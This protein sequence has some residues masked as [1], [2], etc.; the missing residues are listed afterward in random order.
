[1]RITCVT[2]GLL[3]FTPPGLEC[4]HVLPVQGQTRMAGILE[5]TDSSSFPPYVICTFEVIV[6]VIVGI[7]LSQD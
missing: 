1:M 2:V 3:I 5:L 6:V 4:S 7:K